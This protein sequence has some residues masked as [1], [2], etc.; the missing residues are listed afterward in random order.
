MRVSAF[1][2]SSSSLPQQSIAP[3][4]HA[5]AASRKQTT[6]LYYVDETDKKNGRG[7]GGGGGGG[8]SDGR[9]DQQQN[10]DEPAI[11]GWNPFQEVKDMFGNWDDVMDDFFHKRMGKLGL[12]FVFRRRIVYCTY[13]G[14]TI[15]Y[16]VS[17]MYPMINHLVCSVFVFFSLS[18]SLSFSLANPHSHTHIHTLH[19]H[20]SMSY[21]N[22]C[23]YTVLQ[24]MGKY[25]MDNASTNH[26]VVRIP[27]VRTMVWD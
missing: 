14:T 7:G 19:V 3:H 11:V 5:K 25:F 23:L 9:N 17:P 1:Q 13:Y 26:L 21:M 16:T 6:V 15:L 27:K 10:N 24:G 8:D 2:P 20:C 22:V 12:C 4:R 18:L